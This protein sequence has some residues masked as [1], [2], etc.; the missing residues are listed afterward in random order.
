M[1]SIDEASGRAPTRPP[2]RARLLLLGA[3]ALIGTAVLATPAAVAAGPV[4]AGVAAPTRTCA[5]GSYTVARGDGWSI[6]A[7]KLGSTTRA[8]LAANGATARTVLHPGQTICAPTGSTGAVTQPSTP[9][10]S[11]SSG[12]TSGSKPATCSNG[13]YTIERGDGWLAIAKKVGVTSKALLAANNATVSTALFAG[14]TLCLPNGAQAPA[15]GA[16]PTPATPVAAPVKTFTAAES[17]AIVRA[18]WPDELEAEVMR[19]VMRES[20][21]KNTAKNWCCYGLFQIHW[22]A[23][24]PWLAGIGVTSPTQ[25][26]DPTTNANAAY[27]LYQRAG[28][29]RPWAL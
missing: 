1:Y 13:T 19:I 15:A 11:G 3:A 2:S 27:V 17:E 4:P 6:I 16:T 22:N 28:G 5:A 29:F 10:S 18:V 21:L 12:L 9:S 25:L 8:L 24:K 14:R 23:H 7:R 20:N 26:L